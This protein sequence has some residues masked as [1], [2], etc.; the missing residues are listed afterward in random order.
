GGEIIERVDPGA[1]AIVVSAPDRASFETTV[2][3]AAGKTHVVEVPELAAPSDAVAGAA[4]GEPDEP[5]HRGDA[6]PRKRS[7]V[8]LALGLGGAGALGLVVS[9]VVALGAMSTYNSAFDE[10][11]CFRTETGNECD[12]IGRARIDDA[13]TSANVATWI[14]VAGGMFAVTGAIVYF[15]APRER[16]TLTPAATPTSVGL[17]LSA[18]F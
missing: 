10:G 12:P 11:H 13:A 5:S 8:H 6:G 3:A 9:G 16:V 4:P 17:A 1:L 18:G 15:T 14:A 7:R 2:Q